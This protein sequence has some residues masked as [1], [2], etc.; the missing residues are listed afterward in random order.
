MKQSSAST[1]PEPWSWI[2]FVLFLPRQLAQRF[3]NVLRSSLLPLCW[4]PAVIPF[5]WP[6]CMWSPR[7]ETVPN[8]IGGSVESL[9]IHPR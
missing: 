6:L 2:S 5:A 9:E 1:V 7:R 8:R 4:N 3:L